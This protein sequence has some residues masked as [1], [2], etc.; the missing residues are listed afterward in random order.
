MSG[1]VLP[2]LYFINKFHKDKKFL[3]QYKNWQKNNFKRK[4][5]PSID[6]ID[7]NKGY[8][9][10]N[11]QFISQSINSRKDYKKKI[12]LW[13]RDQSKLNGLIFRIF[14]SQ[15]ECSNYLKIS[16]AY[17]CKLLKKERNHYHGWNIERI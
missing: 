9:L 7:N 5:A 17:L 2:G 3:T 8:T 15:L 6:R 13:K 14:D 1:R 11:L 4:F 16:P 10:D 12:K